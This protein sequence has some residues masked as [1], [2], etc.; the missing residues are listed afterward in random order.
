[1][2]NQLRILPEANWSSTK[3]VVS[4]RTLEAAARKPE[5]RQMTVAADSATLPVT[6]GSDRVGARIADVLLYGTAWVI[7]AVWGEGEIDAVESVT[8]DDAA[9]PAG[10]TATHYTGT[11]GQTVNATLVSAYAAQSP[12]V[13]YADALPGVAYSVLVVPTTAID[14]LQQITAKLRG[15]KLYDPRTGTTVYSANPALA[16][17][18]WLSNATY[19]AGRTV[20]W[21]SV[22]AAANA[23]D[24]AVGGVERRKIGLTIDQPQDP[25][26]WADVLRAYA[27]CWVLQ[28]DSGLRLIADGVA[29]PTFNLEHDDGADYGNIVSIGAL[30]TRDVSDAPTVMTLHYTDTSA[31][32]WKS[33]SVT[34][35]APGVL[36]GTT[37]RRPSDVQ[38]PGI[39]SASQATRE[40]TE[41]LNKL[42]LADLS[43]SAEVFDD[44]LAIEPGDVGTVTHPV[45]LTGKAMRV[46]SVNG[47]DGRYALS[48]VEY[49]AAAYSDAVVTDPSSPDT[50]LP[51]PSAPTPVTGLMLSE[52]VFQLQDGTY[53]SRIRAT[54]TAP[55]GFPASFIGTYRVNV[56]AG[57]T[58]VFSGTAQADATTWAT[59]A[60]QEATAYQVDV[61][62]ISRTGAASSAASATI[63]AAG[64]QLVPG[65]VPSLTGFEVGG[66]VRLSWTPAV[67]LDIWRYEIRY[68]A[69]AGTWANATLLDRTD[70]LRFVTKDV[71]A[72]AWDFLVKAVDSVGQYSAT[73]A[74]KSITVTSDAGSF[75][76]D[77]ATFDTP[78][79]SNMTEY[80]LGRT[81]TTRRFVTD[82]GVAWNT[83]F[84]SA[85]STYTNALNSYGAVAS[86]FT[87][88]SEDFGSTISGNWR[89]ELSATAITGAVT[90]ELQ[91][92]PDG[93][94]W[95]SYPS[96]VAKT[97]ARFAR[98]KASGGAS[99][100][101]HVTLPTALV[102][103]DATPRPEPFQVTT[104]SSGG[105]LV[106]L[107]NEY[108]A[109][110][111][112][113]PASQASTARMTTYDRVL[114]APA[115]GL[116]LQ[117]VVPT[118]VAD[119]YVFQKFSDAGA[120][121]IAS[122]DYL[123]YDVFIVS[124]TETAER[125][126]F[127][128]TFSDATNLRT[129]GSTDANGSGPCNVPNSTIPAGQWFSRKHPLSAAVGKT[130]SRIDLIN[131]CDT[132][133]TNITV[134]R[135]LRITDGA[136]TT[137]LSLWTSGEPAFNTTSL[138]SNQGQIQMGTANSFLVYQ[139]DA[140]GT[141]VAGTASGTFN[142]I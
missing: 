9:M 40:A 120:R 86:S 126:G 98:L 15:R 3:P 125:G 123:E 7:V 61:L 93:S 35:Y 12:A 111:S 142:G 30:K 104:L 95:E 128:I 33:A 115:T 13:T 51:N 124:A 110:K 28:G 2:T 21:S 39:Q 53:S 17:A 32:P 46:L 14:N 42:T 71:P 117:N 69:V 97:G 38:M 67:D 45:G 59:A 63:T 114:V 113:T 140:A 129:L 48:L 22:S 139:F 25:F 107:A 134:Y 54:W 135:N 130:V 41:R 64:K 83:K 27:G 85:M 75:L 76:V 92:G 72:G 26:Q 77:S 1:M 87:T 136:S 137:R 80:Q 138:Q 132:A 100:I 74:R 91:V 88:E 82:N 65:N 4:R 89:A 60:V 84:S 24:A 94:A 57:G 121:V 62:T 50:S 73:E 118:T 18:D 58:V 68:V 19:G 37:P 101:I 11:A 99:D 47:A 70:S 96:L 103:I 127:D 34:V 81:D 119:A 56:I 102:R 36:A 122:G 44:G 29:S 105:A 78:T 112:I 52:E 23:C 16:L 141:Q 79:L 90:S 55:T 8:F 106:Q 43:F 66:E 6:Y 109:A 31:V 49:D 131:A 108:V 20:D 5:D 116:L 10:A 133:G